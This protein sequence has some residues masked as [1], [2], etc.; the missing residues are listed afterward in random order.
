MKMILER[1]L[2]FLG[3]PNYFVDSEGY[4]FNRRTR[5]RLKQFKDTNGYLQ[6]GLCK[7]GK[8]RSFLVHRLVAL[9]FI[10]NPHP[11]EWNQ[12]NHKNEDKTNNRVTNLEWCDCEYNNNYGT[13]NKRISQTLSIPIVQYTKQGEFI[14]EWDSAYQVEKEKGFDSWTILEVCRGRRKTAYKSIWKYKEGVSQK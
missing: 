10:P 13:R 8:T 5:R 9:A 2:A 3:Y 1:N 12:V 14:R 11:N 7:D 6:V 4:V